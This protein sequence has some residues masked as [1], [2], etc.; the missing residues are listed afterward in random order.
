VQ[1]EQLADG[2]YKKQKV[3]SG[4]CMDYTTLGR[5]GL[6][7]SVAGLGCGGFSRLGM[8][9]GKSEAES[10]ALVRL[11]IDNG[12][13]L[14]DTAANYGTEEIVGNAISA[15]P[16]ESIVVTTK[17]STARGGEPLSAAQ[18]IES[19]EASLRRLGT[20]YVDV[21]QLHGVLPAQYDHAMT[22]LVPALMRERERGKFRFL[23][24]T[25]SGSGDLEHDMLRRAAVDG[26]WDVG[27]VAFN[28]LH[29]T[30][31]D[32][33]FPL[34]LSNGVGTLVMHA[35]RSI[36]ARPDFLAA[37][38]RELALA[39]HVP[40]TLAES[41]GP[42]DFLVHSGGAKSV[43]DAAYRFARHTPGVDVVLFGTGSAEHLLANIASL[44]QPPLPATDRERLLELFGGVRGLGLENP[45]R[46]QAQAERA[47]YPILTRP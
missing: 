14:I 24:I 23:G 1:R 11:A 35:V 15:V 45:S 29:R 39:G 16:R 20:D 10:V 7:V 12:I 46:A 28:M 19:L 33:L 42:L 4:I 40:A 9:T 47:C 8:S 25:E 32:H 17:C 13:T 6:R 34:T 36:F 18:V 37:S 27:M 38:I 41:D 22:T 5:T 31:S 21:F 30:A 43:T 44:S 3:G 2:I 26:V